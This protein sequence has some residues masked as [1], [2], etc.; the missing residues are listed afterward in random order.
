MECLTYKII[1]NDE[2]AIFEFELRENIEPLDLKNIQLP[3]LL[4]EGISTK[5]A[6]VSG[7]GPIWLYGFIIHHFH[8]CKAVAVFDPRL[9]V[10]VV[11]ESHSKKYSIGD[12][13][14]VQI[15]G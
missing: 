13:I 4:R 10:A 14:D 8:P 7:R 9:G 3:D 2:L 15:G 1:K 11:V 12:T 5:V 6:V